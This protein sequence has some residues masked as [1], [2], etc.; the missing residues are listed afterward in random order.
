M[1]WTR[2]LLVVPFIVL[3]LASGEPQALACHAEGGGKQGKNGG[4]GD[5][6]GGDQGGGGEKG[7][8]DNG[9]GGNGF[10]GAEGF[11]AKEGKGAGKVS[12]GT[13]TEAFGPVRGAEVTSRKDAAFVRFEGPPCAESKARIIPLSPTDA[14]AGDPLWLGLRMNGRGLF[15]GTL[16]GEKAVIVL[17][18]SEL[19]KE[20]KTVDNKIGVSLRDGFI[21]SGDSGGPAL[22][23]GG[24][25]DPTTNPL[26]LVQVGIVSVGTPQEPNKGGLEGIAFL[27]EMSTKG[28]QPLARRERL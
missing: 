18:G 3:A 28:L 19:S 14:K 27:R 9:G 11:E 25:P 21:L 1:K 15:G 12:F 10:E 22:T 8:A 13:N 16:G 17:N 7:G 26:G 23:Q 4:G 6:E 5:G 24:S 20:G 2:S